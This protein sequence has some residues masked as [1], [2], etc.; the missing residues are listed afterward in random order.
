MSS[1]F[2]SAARNRLDY[3]LSLILQSPVQIALFLIP[4]LVL[5]SG[6][7]GGAQLTLV[8]SPLL[9]VVLAV[10]TLIAA[11]VVFDGESTWL[12]GACLVGLYVVIATAFWWG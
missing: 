9:A 6:V 7:L 5:L 3:A 4:V 8:L 2:S 10:T 12:E 11:V 1:A